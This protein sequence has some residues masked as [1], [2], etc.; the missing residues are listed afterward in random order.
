MLEGALL[1]PA[2]APRWV[3]AAASEIIDYN[4]PSQVLNVQHAQG[5]YAVIWHIHMDEFKAFYSEDISKAEEM[6]DGLVDGLFAAVL[7]SGDAGY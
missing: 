3:P 2:K 7:F 5:L 4:D 1:H 6:F